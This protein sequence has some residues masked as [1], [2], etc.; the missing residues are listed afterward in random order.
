MPH[1]QELVKL[2]ANEPFVLIGVN[3]GDDE[4]EYRT[5]LE[6]YGVTWLSAYQ[7]DESP[8]AEKFVVQG[9]PTYLV[10]DAEG[11]IQ[12]RGHSGQAIDSVVDDL[13]EK[14]RKK[15]SE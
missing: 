5:G 10:I 7:G 9:Y 4:E 1:L 3:T 2:H 14:L 12:H 6:K 13:L 8:I 11:K 15:G